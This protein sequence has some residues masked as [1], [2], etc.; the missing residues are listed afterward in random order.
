MDQAVFVAGKAKMDIRR[1]MVR[2]IEEKKAV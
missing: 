2:A 1:K